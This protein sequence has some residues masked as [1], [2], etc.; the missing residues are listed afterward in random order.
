[1]AHHGAKYWI[2]WVG[3]WIDLTPTGQGRPKKRQL[4]KW[5]GRLRQHEKLLRKQ[6]RGLHYQRTLEAS[7]YLS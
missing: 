4:K 2:C 3:G 6:I 1:M 7:G 5:R